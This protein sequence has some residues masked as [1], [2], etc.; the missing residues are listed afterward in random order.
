MSFCLSETP[1]VCWVCKRMLQHWS[2]WNP[3]SC[4][5]SWVSPFQ[6]AERQM[7]ELLFGTSSSAPQNNH[8][9]SSNYSVQK[10]QP[11][12]PSA[13]S[14]F[15]AY[16]PAGRYTS[17]SSPAKQQSYSS[18][19]SGLDNLRSRTNYLTNLGSDERYWRRYCYRYQAQ[20]DIET[21]RNLVLRKISNLDPYWQY[22][23]LHKR[24]RNSY[25]LIMSTNCVL[26]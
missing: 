18:G 8:S 17:S 3:A 9:A 21:K 5:K 20:E 15:S 24:F 19:Y 11:V 12:R 4:D 22:F 13:T 10:P 2:Y 25:P 26:S 7:Q 6:T 16:K 14:A 23:I 1:G